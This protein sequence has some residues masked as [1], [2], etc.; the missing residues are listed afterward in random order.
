MQ[1]ALL[2]SRGQQPAGG[3]QPSRPPEPP[4]VLEDPIGAIEHRFRLHEQHLAAR[5]ARAE[6]DRVRGLA[7]M[8]DRLGQMEFGADYE[9]SIRHAHGHFARVAEVQLQIE[10][11]QA[12]PEAIREQASKNAAD[13]LRRAVLGSSRAGEPPRR[14]IM[15]LAEAVG[16]KRA[17]GAGAPAAPVADP[18]ARAKELQAA[19]AA[20]RSLAQ[21]GGQKAGQSATGPSLVEMLSSDEFDDMDALNSA[22]KKRMG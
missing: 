2:A 17:G 20:A 5:E 15:R 8:E 7:D 11:P 1:E 9:G 3:Q 6:A 12:D 10:H 21:P 16:F 18:V 19:Q 4:S 14:A 22:L 13:Y